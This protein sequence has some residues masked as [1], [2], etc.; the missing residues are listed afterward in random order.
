[1]FEAAQVGCDAAIATVFRP[2]K[3]RQQLVPHKSRLGEAMQKH[4][5]RL[6]LVT[7]AAAGQR[8]AMG[9][10]LTAEFDHIAIDSGASHAHI[11]WSGGKFDT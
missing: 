10:S 11:Y 6:A 2:G 9:E 4:Q 1:M 3:V 8:D 7:C 5:D